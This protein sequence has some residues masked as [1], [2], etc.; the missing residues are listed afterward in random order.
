MI[1]VTAGL[2]GGLLGSYFAT[3]VAVRLYYVWLWRG[4]SADDMVQKIYDV[5]DLTFSV[6][7]FCTPPSPPADPPAYTAEE[8][9]QEIREAVGPHNWPEDKTRLE[10]S[11]GKLIVVQIP[12]MHA[13]ISELLE[14]VRRTQCRQVLIETR[15][16]AGGKCAGLLRALGGSPGAALTPEQVRR[17]RKAIRD[18]GGKE[19]LCPRLTVFNG[20]AASVSAFEQRTFKAGYDEG[21]GPL[22]KTIP[23]GCRLRARSAVSSDLRRVDVDVM[24]G[25]CRLLDVQ[26]RSTPHGTAETPVL[27]D[28]ATRATVALPSGGWTA[29]LLE[30]EGDARE[31][32]VL[33][34]ALVVDFVEEEQKL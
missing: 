22:I 15:F 33:V 18:G 19:I 6:T 12:E 30:G 5:R 20:Q 26:R 21:G 27:D 29:L 28:R 4:R 32:M 25:Y 17:L 23:L 2:V 13:R 24:A 3:P 7:S 8:L 11:N 31:V 9:L 34:R 10:E 14:D 1:L 16:V